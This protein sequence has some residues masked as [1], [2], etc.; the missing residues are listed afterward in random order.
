MEWITSNIQWL[1]SGIGVLFFTWLISF[2]RTAIRK[3][4]TESVISGDNPTN[5]IN[6]II[7]PCQH[8]ATNLSAP[9]NLRGRF[10]NKEG[11]I[12]AIEQLDT[13]VPI[14]EGNYVDINW[15]SNSIRITIKH[16]VDEKL[17]KGGG[18]NKALSYELMGM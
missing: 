3:N 12:L 13:E 5:V 10:E 18:F 9:N 1:F 11:G 16:I 7:Q 8:Q 6:N 4:K 2:A 17:K 15:G 14:N